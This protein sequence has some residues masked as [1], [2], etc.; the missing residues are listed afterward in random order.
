V[1]CKLDLKKDY[2][3]VNWSFILY[4]LWRCGFGGNGA[5]GLIIVSQQ[6]GSLS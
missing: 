3:H 5:S 6:C 4:M 1:L 2:D